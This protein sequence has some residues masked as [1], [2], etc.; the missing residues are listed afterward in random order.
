MTATT[1][2]TVTI[3]APYVIDAD[4]LW[5]RIWGAD[6]EGHSWY[7]SLRFLNGCN[8]EHHGTA[9]VVMEDPEDEDKVVTYRVTVETLALALSDL[10][11]PDHLRR[12]IL[13]DDADC[14]SADGVIQQAV[15]GEI[16]FG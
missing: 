8:W 3:H 9:E 16:V 15:Y 4:A 13:D 2:R 5:S 12:D 6:P 11:F 1:K 7:H 10:S 14:G